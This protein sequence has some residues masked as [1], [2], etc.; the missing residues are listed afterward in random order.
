MPFGKP[1]VIGRR[2]N[3]RRADQGAGGGGGGATNPWEDWEELPL[4]PTDSSWH[5]V[6]SGNADN[7][8]VICD[9]NGG[10][11]RARFET[12]RDYQI[13]GTTNNGIALIRKNP[14]SWWTAA[15]IDKPANRDAHIFEPEAIQFKLEVQFNTD[16]GPIHG[17]GIGAYH[18]HNFMC[19]A[20]FSMYES[21]QGGSPIAG[22]TD[23]VWGGAML[24]KN[25]GGA[26]SGSSSTNMFRTGHKTRFTNATETWGTLWK[27]QNTAGAGANDAIVFA[28]GALRS[29]SATGTWSRCTAMA[30]GYSTTDPFGRVWSPSFSW[31]D[32][33]TR[34]SNGYY[35]H[36]TIFFGSNTSAGQAGEMK[37]KRI[38]MLIQPLANREPLKS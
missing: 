4:D 20:G 18:A 11:L 31:R 1:L 2:G 34:W 15:G 12:A 19:V 14:I 21:D 13:Q 25:L 37:I 30:G 9:L 24:K 26:P 36:P 8:D 16:D 23:V 38:R 29:E 17:G 27:G 32:N 10:E 7:S 35:I 3:L 33:F 5:L 22:G 6:K 28:S